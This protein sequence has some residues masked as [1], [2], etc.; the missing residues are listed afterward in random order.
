[1]N[2]SRKNLHPT[3]RRKHVIQLDCK[4]C[5]N[6]VCSRGMKAI[7]L[8]DTAVELYST[9]LP[10]THAVDL[11]FDAYGTEKCRCKIKDVACL[12]C[13]N[14]V[15]YMVVQPCSVCLESCNNG[16]FWMF[17]SDAITGH[18][19]LDHTGCQILL[20]G[21]LVDEEGADKT[22]HQE[23]QWEEECC[24]WCSCRDTEWYSYIY[25]NITDVSYNR[26]LSWLAN[27]DRMWKKAIFLK[28][29]RNDNS[30]RSKIWCICFFIYLDVSCD[31]V[32]LS[33]VLRNRKEY[34][35]AIR[36]DIASCRKS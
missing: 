18:D 22:Q 10:P 14:V 23:D 33:F 30:E 13:G 19:R 15:G 11:V 28:N 34:L 24:R 36:F 1:M 3:F 20:W 7:L 8:A 5:G 16:H 4:Y 25:R 29:K 26:P 9:D 17:H 12:G 6:T 32:I 31:Q 2:M 27:L 35:L 21:H